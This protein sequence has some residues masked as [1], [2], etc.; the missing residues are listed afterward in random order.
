M[1]GQND[2]DDKNDN[3]IIRI[4]LNLGGWNTWNESDKKSLIWLI[5]IFFLSAAPGLIL[6][7]LQ[8]G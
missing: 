7:L 2:K 4:D 1:R 3:N 8:C 5:G 6:L